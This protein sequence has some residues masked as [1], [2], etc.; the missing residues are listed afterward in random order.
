MGKVLFIFCIPKRWQSTARRKC[1]WPRRGLHLQFRGVSSRRRCRDAAAV[2]SGAVQGGAGIAKSWMWKGEDVCG[3][4]STCW[5]EKPSRTRRKSE[6]FGEVLG[7]KKKKKRWISGF[8]PKGLAP[9]ESG[10][11]WCSLELRGPG[12]LGGEFLW[13]TQ[14]TAVRKRCIGFHSEP[15]P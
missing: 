8:A 9:R 6:G 1:L 3:M 12:L 14:L 4:L 10:G 11:P 13:R 5:M 7:K 15:V 2:G